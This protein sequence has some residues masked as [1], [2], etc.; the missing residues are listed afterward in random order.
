MAEAQLGFRYEKYAGQEREV[1]LA[2]SAG[3]M[4]N[5]DMSNLGIPLSIIGAKAFLSCKSVE[6]LILPASLEAV[7]DWAFAHMKNLRELWLP[8]KDIAFGKQVFLGCERLE[9]IL[10]CDIPEH[11]YYEGIPY[12][13]ASAF[14]FF[15]EEIPKNLKGAGLA[16]PR[17]PR[18]YPNYMY[19][20]LKM[21]GDC[22]GQWRWVET[23]D[24]ALEAFLQRSDDDGFTPAFIGWFYVV[25][26]EDQ[27]QTYSSKKREDKAAL[28]F[29]RLLYS[30]GM[31]REMEAFLKQYLQDNAFVIPALFAH[32]K[33]MRDD[34]R[35]Y[36]IWQAAG[37]LLSQYAGQLMEE[38]PELE[39]EIR[40]Y[41]LECLMEPENAE[42][43][44][45]AGLKL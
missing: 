20:G 38:G 14:R 44:F 17:M 18:E 23:Y 40:S 26:V 24:R 31:S 19:Y 32:S 34:L 3:D 15:A 37:A 1:R 35:Y 9:R 39:P 43:G 12:F 22:E 21:A 13:L 42:D 45:F 4:S 5:L 25:D 33:T 6:R 16:E 41:L 7:E 10:F 2:E 36:K 27:R 30:E 11:A 8:A 29:Q 28:V